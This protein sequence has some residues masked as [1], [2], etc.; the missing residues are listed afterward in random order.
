MA[1]EMKRGPELQA[2]LLRAQTLRWVQKG[3]YIHVPE[4]S[5]D[6]QVLLSSTAI[7]EDHPSRAPRDYVSDCVRSLQ[8]RAST[9]RGKK[10]AANE[11]MKGGRAQSPPSLAAPYQG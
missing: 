2:G 4:P 7:R 3:I 9:M 6:C 11:D 8:L 5:R 10:K 1:K